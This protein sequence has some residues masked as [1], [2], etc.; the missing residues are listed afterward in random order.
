MADIHRST[1]IADRLAAVAWIC[2]G[3][4]YVGSEGVAASAFS[5]RYSYAE[6]YISDLGVSVCGTIYDGRA[7]CSPLH[8][9]MN[10][11]FVFQGVMFLGAAFAIARAISASTRYVFVAFAALNCIGNLLIGFFPEN[12]PGL[13]GGGFSCHVVGALL[14][15]LFGNGAALASAWTFA[16]LRLA[17]VHR[18]ASIALP[19]LAAVAFTMLL[20]SRGSGATTLF[21][22]GIWE[23]ISVYTITG[24][25]LLS[26]LCVIA[27]T[28]RG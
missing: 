11:G 8:A 5:P 13:L 20:L 18:L 6:N 25:E 14:A 3:V 27:R 2:I 26:G 4:L 12:T 7:I 28:R 1:R 15:I 21:P 19:T 10:A 16:E 17:R 9:L 22:D 23:R 24:W